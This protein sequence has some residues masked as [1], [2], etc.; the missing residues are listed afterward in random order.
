M[1]PAPQVPASPA[2]AVQQPSPPPPQTQTDPATASASFAKASITVTDAL[3]PHSLPPSVL[4]LL[5]LASPLINGI[6]ALLH[7]ATWTAPVG[8]GTRSTLLLLAWS[9]ICLF[10]YPLLRYAPQLLI[11]AVILTSA[12]PNVLLPPSSKKGSARSK[13]T[14]A[15]VPTLNVSTLTQS[16]TRE[17]LQKLSDILDVCSTL[18]ARLVLPCWQA[19]TWQHPAGPS[20]TI[21]VAILSVTLGTIWTACFADWPSAWARLS[22]LVPLAPVWGL[23]R[24]GACRTFVLAKGAYHSKL[25]HHVEPRIPPAA[26]AWATKALAVSHAAHAWLLERTPALPATV[27]VS[28]LPPFPLFSLSLSNVFLAG[29]LIALSWCST[30]A[31]LVR[32]A[33]WK[34]ATIRWLARSGLH[35]FSGGYLGQPGISQASLAASTSSVALKSTSS[36]KS[37]GD[38]KDARVNTVS[39][40]FELYENQRWWMGLDWTAALLPQERAS[41]TDGNLSP[42]SPPSS[43]TLPAESSTMRPAPTKE[44]PNAWEKRTVRWKWEED[45]WNV[46]I[47][48]TSG[49]GASTV[50]PLSP[51]AGGADVGSATP[52]ASPRRTSMSSAQASPRS[53][54]TSS[55]NASTPSSAASTLF[56]SFGVGKRSSMS[57]ASPGLGLSE[58]LAANGAV[59]ASPQQAQHFEDDELLLLEEETDSAGWRYGDNSWEKMGTKS[60]LGK[61]TRRRR[62]VRRAR[63]EETVEGGLDAP[64]TSASSG[65]ASAPRGA[66]ADGEAQS[67]I[68]PSS[69]KPPH[70]D[71]DGIDGAQDAGDAAVAPPETPPLSSPQDPAATPGSPAGDK[72]SSKLDLKARLAQAANTPK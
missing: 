26:L 22:T 4:R 6:H 59:A 64:E 47:N 11:L 70:D 50:A 27:R 7:L 21:G 60:G 67:S 69:E 18:H 33:L 71:G 31:T 24:K 66:D 46:V 43:F 62:W 15:S 45:E 68:A 25:H 44:K 58:D 12:V 17:L 61:Y 30:Y 37:S 29:G 41:W 5:S 10:A 1:T 3:S 36:T 16:Q 32:Y 34:S 23:A 53:P 20:V 56:S 49:G 63:M 2:G 72:R 40:R 52:T 35:L 13:P 51:T 39:Y 42:V 65:D 28:L 14:I 8:G 38:A 54:T 55:L 57:A 48:A 19:L 9:G